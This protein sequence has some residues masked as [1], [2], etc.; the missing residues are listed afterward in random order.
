MEDYIILSTGKKVYC[1]GNVLGI[2]E[3]S[4]MIYYGSDGDICRYTSDAEVEK[5][6]PGQGFTK[7][8]KL[9]IADMAIKWWE[10]FKSRVE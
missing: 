9:E 7:E 4:E 3:E 8:E 10:L 1:Y 6:F 2:D 5:K